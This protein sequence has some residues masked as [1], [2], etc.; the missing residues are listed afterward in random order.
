MGQ[1]GEYYYCPWQRISPPQSLQDQHPQQAQQSMCWPRSTLTSP[2][3]LPTATMPMLKAHNSQDGLAPTAKP[4]PHQVQ[5]G[6]LHLPTQ[7][8][9]LM[10][11]PPQTFFNAGGLVKID[12]SK[13]STGD[14]GDPEWNDLAN[15]L[16]GDIYISGLATSHTIAGTPYTGT[17]KIGGTG[18]Q[19]H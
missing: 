6:P 19:P 2:T 4:Q 17:T 12:V 8:H 18:R 7:L 14:L 16:C 1:F 10:P 9:L 13:T 5:P 11:H 3:A 15:T